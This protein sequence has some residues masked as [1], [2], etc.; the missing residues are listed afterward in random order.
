M[1]PMRQSR[2][3]RLLNHLRMVRKTVGESDANQESSGQAAVP[4]G[5]TFGPLDSILNFCGIG[6]NQAVDDRL[7]VKEF[8]ER[9]AEV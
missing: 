3:Q 2:R 5:Y 7:R 4:N 8:A 1:R 6:G 9:L